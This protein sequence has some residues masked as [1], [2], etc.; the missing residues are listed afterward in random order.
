[1][2]NE[3]MLSARLATPIGLLG[4]GASELGVAS[5]Q[6]SPS[7][8][9][10]GGE[11]EPGSARAAEHLANALR[12]LGEYFEGR[13]RHFE[14][15]LDWTGVAGLRLVVL[16]ELERSV[17][18]GRTTTYG[19]LAARVAAP[20]G[21]RAIGAIMGSN[22]LPF[23]VPC[24]RVLATDG[25]GGFGGGL[26]TKEWLLALEGVLPA[27]LDYDPLSLRAGAL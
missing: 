14:L 25:L 15:S 21:A 5:I 24:H 8:S 19:E 26:R 9:K 16:Q 2:Q 13:R 17:A 22:P 6:F 7:T 11:E 27:T 4:V 1:M 18:F 12:Q 20:D 10:T 23:V 3:R